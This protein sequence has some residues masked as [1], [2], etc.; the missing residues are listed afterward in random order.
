MLRGWLSLS[1][2]D[3]SLDYNGFLAE[4]VRITS[5]NPIPVAQLVQSHL[6]FCSQASL[7]VANTQFPPIPTEI[8]QG[9]SKSPLFKAI[10]SYEDGYHIPDEIYEDQD[11]DKYSQTA[12]VLVVRT[13]EESE[14]SAPINFDQI[15][16]YFL[17]LKRDD[18]IS[19]GISSDD[20]SF[21]YAAGR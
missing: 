19:E 4:P 12:T 6:S 16:G 11:L 8:P 20:N 7:H 10:I 18:P 14:L 17:P 9:T 3:P 15:K 5:K 13:R 2:N 1:R 21:P